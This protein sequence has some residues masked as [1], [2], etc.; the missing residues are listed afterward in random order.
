M[1]LHDRRILSLMFLSYM[2]HVGGNIACMGAK[3]NIAYHSECQGL[4]D[5]RLLRDDFDGSF[6][7]TAVWE[8]ITQ[9]PGTGQWEKQ[10]TT[11]EHL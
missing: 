4:V 8:Q 11:Q 9:W 5:C 10:E 2:G 1:L 3:L 7:W 6:S